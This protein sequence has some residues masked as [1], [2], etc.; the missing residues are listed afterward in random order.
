[1][2]A[3]AGLLGLESQAIDQ[4]T[5]VPNNNGVQ[6]MELL[7]NGQTIYRHM[8]NNIP[9]DQ[10]RMIS[11]H[12][13]FKALKLSNKAFQRLYVADG[14]NLPI[15]EI[16]ANRGRFKVEEGKLYEVVANLK[17]SYNNITQLRIMLRGESSAYKPLARPK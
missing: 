12:I 6:A 7:I 14:N 2:L 8:L 3:A 1:T 16:D 15:Y 9:F 5:G 4:Y 17:D 11:A 10:S 13:N